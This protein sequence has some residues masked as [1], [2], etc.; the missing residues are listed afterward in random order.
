MVLKAMKKNCYLVLEDGTLYP[1]VS[2]GHPPP[3]AD[4]FDTGEIVLKNAGEIVFNTGMS[5]Y[6]EIVTDPSYAGQI[7]LMTYPHIGNY[8]SLEEWSESGPEQQPRHQV[9]AAGLVVRSFSRGSV[10]SGRKKLDQFLKEHRT[11]GISEIDTRKLTLRLRDQGNCNGVIVAASEK[12]ELTDHD[13]ELC[14]TYLRRF[15]AME[16][17]N[18]V[19]VVGTTDVVTL[20]REAG[21]PHFALFDSGVK[22]NT[23][24]EMSMLDCKITVFPYT[25][26]TETLLSHKPDAVLLSNGPGDPAVLKH[27]AELTKSLIG[28]LPLFGICL[29][30]QLISLAVGGSTYKMKFGHHG[31]N[32]PV[33]DEQT[34]KV[35]VTSQNHGFAVDAH[36]L[37][38]EVDVWLTNANDNSNEGLVH[39]RL[40]VMSVQF[41]P[42][43][44]PGPRDSLWIFKTFVDKVM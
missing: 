37:P 9:K 39:R 18:L 42:E 30:H 41:H 3:S 22:A 34:G 13:R 31:I 20:N 21:G 29:G 28:K 25:A 40:P 6:H 2:F 44:A 33:R 19:D 35:F 36:T 16:G 14:L 1:G 10:P 38:P 24:R 23:I 11:T 27:A 7:V 26:D 4:T 17:R 8:G 12:G 5:G 15:P 43:A 32:H